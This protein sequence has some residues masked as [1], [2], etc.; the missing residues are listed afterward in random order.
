MVFVLP[1]TSY[2]C[3]DGNMTF[4]NIGLGLFISEM[5][6]GLNVSV[7]LYLIISNGVKADILI[8]IQPVFYS[9]EILCYEL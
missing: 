8:A 2:F 3:G 7:I 9:L 6:Y 1:D 5:F 4:V